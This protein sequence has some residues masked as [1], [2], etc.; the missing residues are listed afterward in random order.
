M[1]MLAELAPIRGELI[2]E[3]G[4]EFCFLP[5]FLIIIFGLGIY[6]RHSTK[7]G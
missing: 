6:A 5:F 3:S 4:E 1:R 7:L 2:S